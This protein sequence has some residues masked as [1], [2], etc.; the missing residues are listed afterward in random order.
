MF[1]SCK[2]CSTCL[3]LCVGASFGPQ[4]FESFLYR[5]SAL[6]GGA[7]NPF[8]DKVSSSAMNF[9]HAAE[10]FI[11]RR[12]ALHPVARVSNVPNRKGFIP[13]LNPE[14]S[15]VCIVAF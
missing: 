7:G 5:A 13:T 8:G 2:V 6:Q 1:F 12:K 4:C 10:F 11:I 15:H 3:Q 14:R 9:R